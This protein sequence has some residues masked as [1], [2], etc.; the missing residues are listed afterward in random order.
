MGVRRRKKKRI[1]VKINKSRGAQGRRSKPIP[2]YGP[3]TANGGGEI[4]ARRSPNTLSYFPEADAGTHFPAT[5]F[6]PWWKSRRAP[7]ISSRVF[8]MVPLARKN[9]YWDCRARFIC[10]LGACV[11]HKYPRSRPRKLCCRQKKMRTHG[12]EMK[13]PPLLEKNVTSNFERDGR[14]QRNLKCVRQDFSL[15]P[16]FFLFF[17]WAASIFA[18]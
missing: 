16:F 17:A 14:Q 18:A 15:S 2:R 7:A 10:S 13:T 6:P 9:I 4:R 3:F 11:F 1:N 5:V 12:S 8:L